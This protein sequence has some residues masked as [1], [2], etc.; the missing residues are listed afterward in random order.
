MK[1]TEE[2]GPDSLA[3]SRPMTKRL[4]RLVAEARKRRRWTQ[5]DL[6]E[7]MA[8]EGFTAWRQSTVSKMERGERGGLDLDAAVMLCVLLGIPFGEAFE[9]VKP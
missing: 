1:A 6:G 5:A 3:R 4:G 2:A 9:E 7:R 8:E